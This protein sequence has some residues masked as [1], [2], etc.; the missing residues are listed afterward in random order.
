VAIYKDLPSTIHFALRF[1]LV[2][3]E[4]AGNQRLRFLVW[5]CKIS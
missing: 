3:G 5:P 4:R 2:E 1:V